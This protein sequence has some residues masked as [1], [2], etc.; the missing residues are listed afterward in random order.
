MKARNE[1]ILRLSMGSRRIGRSAC[2]VA[3]AVAGMFA[4]ADA[5][6]Q[7]V[8]A[9]AVTGVSL[10]STPASGGT[11]QR[12]DTIEARVDFD[13][14]VAVTGTPQVN[15]TI[16]GQTRAAA[17]S[18]S[19][20]ALSLFFEYRVQAA[21]G[22][23]DGVSIAADAIRLNGGGIDAAADGTTDADLSHA[24]VSANSGHKVDGSRNEAPSVTGVSFVGSPANGDTYYLGET[25][26]LKVRFHRF[27]RNVGDPQVAL[28]IGGQTQLAEYS[29]ARGRGG[30]SDLHFKHVVQATDFDADGISI[31]ANAIRLNGATIR[32]ASDV[33][34]DA[35]L[36]HAAVADDATRK[37]DGAHVPGP[38]VT[39]VNFIGTPDNGAAYQSGET[40]NVQVWF[41]RQVN[42]TGDPTVELTI[43]NRTRQATLRTTRTGV[44]G[45]GFEYTVQAQDADADGVGIAANAIRLNG[46]S[47]TATDDSTDAALTHPAVPDDR[48]RKVGGGTAPP[49]GDAPTVSSVSFGS[50]PANGDTYSRGE[51]VDVRVLFS[52]RIAVAGRPRLALTIGSTIRSATFWGLH[53]GYTASFRYTVQAAD[54]DADGIGIGANSISLEGGSITAVDDSSDADLAHATMAAD[55]GHKVNG[56]QVAA[57]TV[58]AVSISSRPRGGD[59]Y[60]RGESIVVAI[61]FSEPVRVTGSPRLALTVGGDTR[62]AAFSRS[63]G[64]TIWFG[65]RVRTDD[66]DADGIDVGAGALTLNGG[67]IKDSDKNDAALGLG[68]HAIANAAGHRVDASLQDTSAPEV[69]GVTLAST[70]Q[71]GSAYVIEETIEVVVRFDEAVTVTGSPR[72]ALQ[73]GSG[74]RTAV[75]ASSRLEVVRFHYVVQAGDNGALGV[76]VDGLSL[77]G[78]TILD[79]ADNA[80][81]LRLGSSAISLGAQANGGRRDR[82]P[83]TVSGVEFESSPANGATYERGDIVQAAV[84]FNEPVTVTG[85]PLL[86]LAV[87][88]ATRFA[89]FF[90]A[91]REYVRFRYTVQEEDQ[92]RDGITVAAAGLSLNG[93]AIVDA[94]GNAA[95]LSLA[96]ASVDSGDQMDGGVAQDTVPTRAAVTS[97]PRNG[98]TYGRGESVEVEIRFNKEVNVSGRPLVELSIDPRPAARANGGRLAGARAS[99]SAAVTRRA[100]FVTGA[101]E[102]LQFRYVVQAGDAS[103]GGRLSIA[104]LRLNGGSITDASGKR[105]DEDDLTLATAEVVH[106]GLV[107]GGLGEPAAPRR[108]AVVSVPQADRTYRL[109]EYILVEVQFDK[110]VTITGAPRLE[111]TID[112][113]DNATRHARFVSAGHD[114][115][116]FRYDVQAGD[117][118]DDG[119]EISAGALRL[120]GGSIRDAGRAE[121]ALGLD[122]AEIVVPADKVDGGTTESTPPAVESVLIVSQPR[123]GTDWQTGDRVSVEVRFSEPVIVTGRP[124]L[125]LR[126]GGAVRMAAIST[127]GPA[128]ETIM[129]AY[130]LQRDDRGEDGIGIPANALRLNG[131][132]IRDGVGNDADLRTSEVLPGNQAVPVAQ[133]ACKPQPSST[134]RATPRLASAAGGGGIDSYDA[135]VTLELEENRDGRAQAVELGCVALAD[136]DR[137]YT[138]SIT[139]GD[140]SRFAVGASD[141][142]L[143]YVGAGENAEQTPEYVLTVSATPRGG[144]PVM[145]LEVRIAVVAVD[146][147]G[148]VTLSTMEPLVGERLTASLADL[149]GVASGS[150]AW[151][152]WRRKGSGGVW[153]AIEGAAGATY[154]P[155][156]ADGGFHL[157]ARAGYRDAYGDQ[158]AASARTEAVDL[159]PARRERMLQVGL[160]GF[161]RT[162]GATAVS[163]I[164][165][166][167]SSAMRSAGEAGPMD[168]HV[169]LNRRSVALSE[170]ADAEARADAVRG[171]VEALGVRVL[172]HGEAVLEAPPAPQLLSNSAFR[173]ERGA[174][175]AR[176][177]VWGAG[178]LS[179]FAADVDGFAQE[180]TV[181]SGYLGVDYRFVPN[182]VA[183]LAASYSNLDL[184]S[185]S[186]REG[187]ATLKGALVSVYPYGLWMPEEWLGVWSL[188]GVGMGTL[189]LT[190][191][192]RGMD[193]DI[194]TWLGAVGQ[195]AE[196]WSAGGLSLAAKSDG[197]VTGVTASGGLPG[198]SAHAWRARVLMEAGVELRTQDARFGGLIELGGRLDG[199][200]A[201]RGLGAEAGGELSYT[202]TGIGLGLTGRGRLL[203]VH[204]DA[205]IR[206]WGASLVLTLEPPDHGPGLA[207]SVAPAWGDPNSGMDALWRDGGLLLSAGDGSTL[208]GARSSWL[209]Q[210]T[211]VRVGYGL[212]LLQGAGR[213]VPFAEV[214]F[215]HAAARSLRAGA[216]VEILGPAASYDLELEAYGER[217]AANGQAPR[218]QFGLGGSLEY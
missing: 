13:R 6:G 91:E 139:A 33:T 69:A 8:E 210:A 203:L 22:D 89:S 148:V 166:R 77:N 54:R 96:A 218:L 107:D 204:E 44:P 215:E 106:G 3:L 149:D 171:I 123:S 21:D 92:D 198:V 188:A 131:G 70:P 142:A 25:I 146:D 205:A 199:G 143:R 85:E 185:T 164:G 29:F 145:T 195:R 11:Y 105:L 38:V 217:T 43:G 137:Q 144:G 26:E 68:S 175:G 197:F 104:A 67:A 165:Q 93:G 83:P 84:R 156:P 78:G 101:D 10:F 97:E 28:T 7:T 45:L 153:S 63:S 186:E 125:Q 211:D 177:G 1:R 47:I 30:I 16:G 213:V 129:F 20:G 55:S 12:G 48:T 61:R 127:A 112:N 132:T 51:T 116:R 17:Y 14:P 192:G 162:V 58:S 24:A 5:A 189:E 212:D 108:V 100:A 37:V 161:G 176:W 147:R 208:T 201:E 27:V 94:A 90:S 158:T 155:V 157:Q 15:L 53:Y 49:A 88:G 119:I 75:Y 159:D 59:T 184:T 95:N 60:V 126:V 179:G 82:N 133:L 191:V 18:H 46:G 216:T 86:A 141:G 103:G 2:C 115:L 135:A 182:A 42:V 121:A 136:P 167:F 4:V 99:A 151:Q 150:V 209:P 50:S 66:R 138:Y 57:P 169:T 74:E 134:A 102:R 206:D 31:G 52:E 65:Y 41:D 180:A 187:D 214:G 111:L 35:D 118:D 120:N 173:V 190:D 168:V 80:A 9:P 154:T 170:I 56:A 202:H 117:R 109:G 114:T 178:D 64:N 152:W 73:V 72:L 87:G 32:A 98:E 81:V 79:A 122:R 19:A 130:T 76:P 40:I 163:V 174:G 71:D 181:L 194:R 34:L 196:L 110:G 160:T 207:V 62:S 39:G 124:R 193:G 200:D 36:T 183:G 140:R 128:P 172:P 23:T 113:S